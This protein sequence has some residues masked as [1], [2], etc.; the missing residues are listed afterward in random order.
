[1]IPTVPSVPLILQ[2]VITP[3]AIAQR[4]VIPIE[5]MHHAR[6]DAPETRPPCPRERTIKLADTEANLERIPVDIPEEVF[7]DLS[8]MWGIPEGPEI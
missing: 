2:L 1:M 3:P 8:R 4:T 7:R 6:V 5:E